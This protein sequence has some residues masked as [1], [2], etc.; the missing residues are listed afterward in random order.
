MTAYYILL[1]LILGFYMG[2]LC[3]IFFKTWSN[4]N[5]MYHIV[6]SKLVRGDCVQCLPIMSGGRAYELLS[7]SNET[8]ILTSDNVIP[9]LRSCKKIERRIC[10]TLNQLCK[11]DLTIYA[12]T[13]SDTIAQ[14]SLNMIL[15]SNMYGSYRR[16][17]S[18]YVYDV[19]FKDSDY[20]IENQYSPYVLSFNQPPLYE[21]KNLSTKRLLIIDDV[22]P[23]PYSAFRYAEYIYYLRNIRGTTILANGFSLSLIQKKSLSETLEEFNTQ[24]PEYAQQVYTWEGYDYS[25]M[26][27]YDIGYFCFLNNAYSALPFLE[28]AG[29][30]FIFELYPGGGF[31]LD[32]EETDRKLHA[33]CSSPCFRKVITTQEVTRS[34]LLK[35]RFCQ[36]KDILNIFGVVIPSESFTEL[37]PSFI[38]SIN[39]SNVIHICFCAMKYSSRGEDKGYDIFI[40]VAKR[41]NRIAPYYRFS[42]IGNYDKT[43][44][45]V[46]ELGDSI[47]FL[48]VLPYQDLVYVLAEQHIILSPN[49]ANILSDGSF[50]GFPTASCIEAGLQN[51]LIMCSDPKLLNRGYFVSGEN[52]EIVTEDLNNIVARISFL[53]NDRK[54][55]VK[56]IRAQRERIVALY[57]IEKQL[58]PRRQLIEAQIENE[59]LKEN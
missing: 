53:V 45:D 9:Y 20:N 28:K 31:G 22:F 14:V 48:G 23:S 21:Q 15:S 52:I 25:L 10:S 42:V 6:M 37:N 58:V 8:T 36:E 35:K 40:D 34:Y 47:R 50:D 12:F 4:K 7:I 33:V 27:N 57:S 41:L 39:D 43:T 32:N 30:P 54:Q 46:R 16:L 44:I 3:Q 51:T 24:Y 56:I 49:R 29:L 59:K 17:K 18:D 26:N 1:I 13:A 2:S 38:Q 55:L 5:C 11:V 19:V